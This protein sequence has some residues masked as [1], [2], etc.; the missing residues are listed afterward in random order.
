M[1]VPKSGAVPRVRVTY[2]EKIS[3]LVVFLQFLK[4]FVYIIVSFGFLLQIIHE[5]G[6]QDIS[7]R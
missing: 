1:C 2:R 6:I 4:Y 5:S 3:I 7:P